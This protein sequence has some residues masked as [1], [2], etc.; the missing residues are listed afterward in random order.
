VAPLCDELFTLDFPGRAKFS[1]RAAETFLN[2]AR[3]L[4]ERGTPW[5]PLLALIG[6]AGESRGA[7]VYAEMR[8]ERVVL[9]CL[10]LVARARRFD[11]LLAR[12]DPAGEAAAGSVRR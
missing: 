2:Y 12:T 10:R 3:I 8:R 6:P 4:I 9:S 11:N 5:R 1:H 7:F